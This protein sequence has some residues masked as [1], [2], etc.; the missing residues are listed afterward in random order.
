MITIEQIL[1][2]QNPK[3]YEKIMKRLEEKKKKKK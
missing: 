3:A 1:K 2:E